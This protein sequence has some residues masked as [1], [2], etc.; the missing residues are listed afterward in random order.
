[1]GRGTAMPIGVNLTRNPLCSKV[2]ALTPNPSPTGRG[3]Q[4]I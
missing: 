1:M 2:F 3:E 4:E